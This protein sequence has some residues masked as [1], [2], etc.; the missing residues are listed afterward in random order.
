MPTRC[1]SPLRRGDAGL[2]TPATVDILV[3]GGFSVRVDG[4]ST[5]ADGWSRRS[6]AALVKILALTPCHRMHRERMMDLLWPDDSVERSAP[7][8]HKAAHFA[9]LAAGHRDAIVLRGDMVWLFPGADITVDAVQFE[10]L[11][12]MAVTNDDASLAREALS[13]YGGELLP[14]DRFED[15]AV[16]RREL[17]HLRHLDV[18]RVAGQWRELAELDP[19]HEGAHVELMRQQ[20]AAGDGSAAL[21]QYH[22]LE[23]VLDR[24]LGMTPSKQARRAWRRGVEANTSAR[25]DELLAELATLVDRQN[26]VLAELAD[27]EWLEMSSSPPTTRRRFRGRAEAP[28]TTAPPRST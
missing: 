12:S 2:S 10:D 16:D 14:E 20:L 3:L 7:R 1:P 11:A 18:L 13:C 9:R 6:A 28:S 27:V 4:N 23:R 25:A 15:W 19:T 26:A 8:L 22:R 24:E 17:L 21:R 5:P